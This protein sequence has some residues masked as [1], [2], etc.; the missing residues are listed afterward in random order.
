MNHATVDDFDDIMG[1]FKQYGDLF[2][3]IRGDKITAMIEMLKRLDELTD[4]D[5][6]IIVNTDGTPR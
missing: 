4:A 3:H 6:N 5:G 2:P 1:V